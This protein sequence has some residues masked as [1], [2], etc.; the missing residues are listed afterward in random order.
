MAEK[1]KLLKEKKA[2]A[3]AQIDEQEKKSCETNYLK[4]QKLE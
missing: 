2:Q 1:A 3:K 4:D